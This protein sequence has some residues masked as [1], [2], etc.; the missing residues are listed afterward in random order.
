MIYI[1]SDLLMA[2]GLTEGVVERVDCAVEI[3]DEPLECVG[4]VLEV[5]L[6]GSG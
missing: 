3:R 4:V 6:V 2:V 5:A 1:H